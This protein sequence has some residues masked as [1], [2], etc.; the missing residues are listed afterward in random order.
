MSIE[1]DDLWKLNRF[2]SIGTEGPLYEFG[3]QI[4]KRESAPT[5]S[6][7]IEDGKGKEVVKEVLAYT[8]EGKSI[9]KTPLLFCLA[10]CTRS[11]DKIAKRDAYKALAEVCTLP[12]DLFTFIAFSQTLNNPSKGWGKLQRKTISSW[13]NSKDPK[14]LAENA[15]RYKSKAGWTHKDVLRLTHTKA[16]NDG[17]ALVLKYVIKGLKVAKAEFDS[18]GNAT[19]QLRELLDYLE[20]V[21]TL[22]HSTDDQQVARLVEQH[23]LSY[24]HIPS[25]HLNSSEVWNTLAYRLPLPMLLQNISKIASQGLLEPAND[26]S[27]H[28]IE[29]LKNTDE[30]L[31]SKI[32]PYSVLIAL[33]TYEQGKGLRR[34][35]NRIPHV[36]EAL[37]FTLNTAI[38]N[39]PSTGK[40]FLVAVK[41]DD[42]VFRNAVRGAPVIST[43]LAAALMSMIIA[44]KEDDFQLLLLLPAVA[45]NL[46]I[47]PNMQLSEICDLICSFPLLQN[48][49]DLSLPVKW[50]IAKK[51]LIDVFLV[52][53]DCREC[54][55]DISPGEA[56]KLYRTKMDMPNA[57]YINCAISTNR[58]RFADP[59]DNGMLDIAG[60]DENAPRVI[61]DFV[62]GNL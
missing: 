29:R 9:R 51:S 24:E 8:K 36:V 15:T 62:L 14:Q 40:R 59:S 56:M 25:V 35:W 50:A 32:H 1:A 7:L 28:I 34:K 61:H 46:K 58:L 3:E 37:N 55:S 10:L 13:Y 16:S 26:T 27:K 57:K 6:K 18:D 39:V 22:K 43:K 12:T 42:N 38:Q 20:A 23:Q 48:A 31:S 21:D 2:L 54:I 49:R 53:T 60:F 47:T 30:I 17:V 45:L 4:L 19:G 44:H 11:S 41:A 5:I 33:R 52:I